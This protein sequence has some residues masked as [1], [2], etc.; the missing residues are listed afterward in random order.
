MNKKTTLSVMMGASL[1]L[2]GTTC[3]AGTERVAVDAAALANDKCAY[4]HGDTGNSEHDKVPNIAGFSTVYFIDA[5]TAYGVGDRP[6][7]KFTAEGHDE[8]NM[9]DITAGLS[10][11]EVSAL[12]TYYA[13]QEFSARTQTV[14]AALVKQGKKPY[15]K[16]KKCHTANGS[17]ADDDAGILAGQS[18]SYLKSQIQYFKD[19]TRTQP[20]KMKKAFR[21]LKDGDIE[22]LLHFFAS[23]K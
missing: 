15:R 14:D 4:C 13:G 18:M 20:K 19:G 17:D 12:A 3:I 7:E 11:A 23:Q 8:T 9:K 2:G 22:K 1:L 21:K 6:S 5:M 10:E 16:C